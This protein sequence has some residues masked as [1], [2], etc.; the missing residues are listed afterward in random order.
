MTYL[1]ADLWFFS[2]PDPIYEEAKDASAIIIPHRFPP[3]LN[4]S[5]RFGIY[6][7]GWVT[8]RRD[9][10]GLRLLEWWR[11]RC[12]EWCFD[13]VDEENYRFADQR[14]LD[15][16]SELSAKVCTLAHKGA[17]LAPWNMGGYQFFEREGRILIDG[18]DQLIFFH[19]HGLKALMSNIF[20]TGHKG[21]H[22]QISPLIKEE[23]YRPY[24]HEFCRIESDLGAKSSSLRGSYGDA[25][26]GV[27]SK[28]KSAIAVFR[29]LMANS[30]IWLGHS[31]E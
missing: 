24:L 15:R 23:I 2:S 1:D 7:V 9:G 12:L 14:Y 27:I 17:N 11:Q 5:A 3:E 31:S 4:E 30:F 20:L 29:A 18:Q 6:N 19:F 28:I 13:R 25:S 16:F 21:Y 26:P 10:E 22:A 8:F